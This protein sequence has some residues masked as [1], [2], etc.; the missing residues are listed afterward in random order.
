MS[1]LVFS[2]SSIAAR[3]GYPRKWKRHL[4]D[5]WERVMWRC[6]ICGMEDDLVWLLRNCLTGLEGLPASAKTPAGWGPL[7]R[8]LHVAQLFK[9]SCKPLLLK[10]YFSAV[11]YPAAPCP[12]FS[13]LCA[14]FAEGNKWFSAAAWV[15]VCPKDLFSWPFLF[16]YF[17]LLP[18]HS[19]L[20]PYP[21]SLQTMSNDIPLF[22]LHSR[23]SCASLDTSILPVL[24]LIL[25][26]SADCT[27]DVFAVPLIDPASLNLFF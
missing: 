18:F 14:T 25:Y 7:E 27:A 9:A 19:L 10:T 2:S 11:V 15:S 21:P 22:S 24:V 6:L 26:L 3:R 23:F 1:Q 8:W 12:K 4:Q 5:A 20:V 17:F 16:S 13:L